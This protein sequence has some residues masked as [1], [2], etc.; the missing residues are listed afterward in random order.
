MLRRVHAKAWQAL[1]L[2]RTY[3]DHVNAAPLKPRSCNWSVRYFLRALRTLEKR[4]QAARFRT[5]RWLALSALSARRFE[6]CTHFAHG[7]EV[8]VQ[9]VAVVLGWDFLGAEE[10]LELPQANAGF[11]SGSGQG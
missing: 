10:G 4:G 1:Y 8:V 6:A 5:R 7:L 3:C 11:T 2:G 9:V